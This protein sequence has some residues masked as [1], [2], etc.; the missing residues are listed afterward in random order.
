MKGRFGRLLPFCLLLVLAAH[1]HAA[2]EDLELGVADQ[3]MGGTGVCGTGLSS[4]MSNPAALA[5]EEGPAVCAA[6]RLPFSLFDFAT[7]G[8]DGSLAL[9][10]GL[11]G[12]LSLRMF[13]FEDY[14]EKLAAVTVAGRLGRGMSFGIQ[15]VVAVVDI[16]DGQSSY[17][18]AAAWAVNAGLQAEVYS[19]WMLSASARNVFDAR[20]GESGE[21]FESRLDIGLAYRPSAGLESRVALSRDYR[22]T[23][24]RFGQSV[25][26][27]PVSL[28]AGVKSSPASFTGGIAVEV[29]GIRLSYAVET[30]PDLELTH[31]AGVGYAF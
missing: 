22:G 23:R 1:G 24:I 9:A 10:S 21:R 7:H 29:E 27:G 12:S 13:G 26:V 30:H 6:S 3:A 4:V 15:P 25:P 31:Q 19:R 20:I 18:S 2:F 5:R 16:A 11:T 17:G 14:S 8:L 28:M